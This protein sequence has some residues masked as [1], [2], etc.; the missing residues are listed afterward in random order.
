MLKNRLNL[1]SPTNQFF[2]SLDERKFIQPEKKFSY[3]RR[4]E[5]TSKQQQK[6]K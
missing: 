2:A 4:K 6:N 5:R 1:S 3:E